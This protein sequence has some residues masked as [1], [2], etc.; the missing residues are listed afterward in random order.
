[1]DTTDAEGE[2]HVAR[3]A[4]SADVS[5]DAKPADGSPDGA[6][7]PGE[8]GSDSAP[9]V[10]DAAQAADATDAASDAGL[11]DATT[12]AGACLTFSVTAP[13][14]SAAMMVVLDR[15][16]SMAQSSKW[17]TVTQAL[18]SSFDANAFNALSLGLQVYP[19]SYVGAPDCV[20][21]GQGPTCG[22]ILPNGVACGVSVLPAVPLANSGTTLSNDSSGVRH[23]LYQF[24]SLHNPESSDSGD[25]APGYDAL[26][27]AYAA[28]AAD[29]VDRRV[30]VLITDGGFSCTAVSS[31]SRPGYDDG[32]GC[33]DWEHPDGVNQLIAGAHDDAQAPVR[34]FVVGLPGTNSHGEQQGAYATAPYNMLLALSTY[35]VSGSP[36]TVDGACDHAAAFTQN[37]SAPAQPCHFDLSDDATFS[38]AAVDAALST[39]WQQGLGCVYDVPAMPDGGTFESRAR[40]RVDRDEQRFDCAEEASERVRP[41]HRGRV[42]GL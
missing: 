3:D 26:A 14:T 20:C 27:T 25:V 7:N 31:P 4:S 18:V 13:P 42:L 39:V 24:L 41:M 9:D 1:M 2:S 21:P 28:L 17:T 11:A 5:N 40:Q 36:E 33:G 35:A 15:S 32:S 34:T 12:D 6:V 19:A 16:A 8:G 10:S 30:A 38:A 37:G 22:G 23:D 29:D